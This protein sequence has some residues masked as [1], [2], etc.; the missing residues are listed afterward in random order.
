MGVTDADLGPESPDAA[1]PL[2]LSPRQVTTVTP[3]GARRKKR[4]WAAGV[5]LAFV[6]AAIALIL[7]EG[8]S[9]ASV[10]FCNANEVGKRAECS[11]TKRFRL[12]GTVDAGSI[13]KDNGDVKAFT[14][15]YDG[16]TIPVR[17]SGDPGGI[18]KENIPVVI[19]G[20]MGPDGT[21]LGDRIL[22]KHT[23]QYREANPD[24]VKDYSG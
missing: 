23:E 1:H 16:A 22:V 17:Y 15:S 14:V 12:Q 8:L 3:V 2:D 10:Y 11:T 24:R 6:L 13:Q 9:N 19:E 21:F 7:F 4:K 18:F 20:R 5:V